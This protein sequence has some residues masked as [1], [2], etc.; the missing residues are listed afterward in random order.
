M[1]FDRSL[2]M[3]SVPPHNSTRLIGKIPVTEQCEDLCGHCL[4]LLDSPESVDDE[5]TVHE[6]RVA[7]K[8][9][10]AAWL[11]AKDANPKLANQRRKALRKLS[12]AIADRRDRSVLKELAEELA[13]E[14]GK[15][16]DHGRAF[17]RL[18]DRLDRS[19]GTPPPCSSTTL[20]LLL[21]G[22][23]KERKAW[24]HLD[25]GD[26]IACRRQFRRAL[27]DSEKL[28][29]RRTRE[30]LADATATVWHEWRKAVK[31]LR[32]QREFVAASQGRRPGVRDARIKR[33]GTRLGER[34]DLD[35]LVVASQRHA[36]DEGSHHAHVRKAIA[37]RERQV[38]GNARRLGRLAFL[39]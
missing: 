16:R 30:A 18:A 20:K 25:L 17:A 13:E 1:R 12:G 14:P 24:R 33:L 11:L 10:R 36:N 3:P 29:T 5:H 32:Y 31:R 8:R 28:A 35:N 39:R 26:D 21:A 38:M 7:T 6:I 23:K 22:W 2:K 19:D 9:L 15:H 34:N 4:A 27:R 37:L